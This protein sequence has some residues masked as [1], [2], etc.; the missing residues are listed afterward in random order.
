MS[1]F[2][3]HIEHKL[4]SRKQ[5]RVFL[6]ISSSLKLWLER[7]GFVAI[8]LAILAMLLYPVKDISPTYNNYSPKDILDNLSF[9]LD[10][11]EIIQEKEN[12]P[13]EE[14]NIQ[15]SNIN[16]KI[17]TEKVVDHNPVAELV[18]PSI[19]NIKPKAIPSPPEAKLTSSKSIKK[20]IQS[21]KTKLQNIDV[22][23]LQSIYEKSLDE[24]TNESPIDN[25]RKDNYSNL[26][27]I[28]KL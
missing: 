13:K 6:K 20:I 27:D 9:K 8:V 10:K 16:K 1:N 14:Q 23:E 26:L 17:V 24:L 2:K 15:L 5:K 25:L 12:N 11:N 28:I 21:S 7:I 22:K 4:L 18:V 3:F 19:R